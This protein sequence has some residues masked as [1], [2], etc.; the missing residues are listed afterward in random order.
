MTSATSPH[1]FKEGNTV[2]LLFIK[3]GIKKNKYAIF[4]RKISPEFPD[5]ILNEFIYNSNNLKTIFMKPNTN[6]LLLF[7][8]FILSILFLYFLMIGIYFLYIII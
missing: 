5:D 8:K 6:Y 3:N 7:I 4:L 1:L 2:D